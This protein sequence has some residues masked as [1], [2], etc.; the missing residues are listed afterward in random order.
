MTSIDP[1]AWH[2]GSLFKL[3]KSSLKE[4]EKSRNI[5]NDTINKRL[6][7]SAKEKLLKAVEDIDK[8]LETDKI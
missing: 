1:N 2:I 5:S 4:I 6:L 8:L 3:V 7:R